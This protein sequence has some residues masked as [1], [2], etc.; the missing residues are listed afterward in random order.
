MR[1]IKI[2]IFSLLGLMAVLAISL[3]A[4]K[5][6]RASQAKNIRIP[7]NT[8]SVLKMD[9]DGL[10]WALGKNSLSNWNE[11]YGAK[12]RDS[13]GVKKTKVWNIGVELPANLYLFSLDQNA[14]Q[15][16]AVLTVTNSEKLHQFLTDKLELNIDSAYLSSDKT[17]KLYSKKNIHILVDQQKLLFSLSKDRTADT[18]LMKTLLTSDQQ[19]WQLATSFMDKLPSDQHAD[20][21]WFSKDN[22]WLSV[23]FNNGAADLKGEISSALFR[24]P[25]QASSIFQD[26]GAN[27]II[28]AEINSDLALLLKSQQALVDSLK[29]PFDS[30]DRYV[31]NYLSIRMSNKELS[32]TDTIISYDYNDNFEMVEKKELQQTQVPDLTINLMASPHLLSYLPEKLFYKFNKAA[33]SNLLRMSTGSLDLDQAIPWKQQANVLNLQYKQHAVGAKYLG[34]LPAYDKISSFNLFAVAE[35]DK[36]AK[37]EGQISFNNKGLNAFYQLIDN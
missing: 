7:A 23:Q 29:L 24:F 8:Q 25:K 19:D 27:D 21:T 36:K 33:H 18:A 11:Y 14:D 30:L 12:E 26:D 22:N 31:G 32:Q 34:W 17:H 13:T 35:T 3:F 6:F 16:Y 4:Y 28:R 10:I 1:I 9:V 37:I 5:A 15:Y 20:F 2:T